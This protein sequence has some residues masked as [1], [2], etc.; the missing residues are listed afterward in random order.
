MGLTGGH[1]PTVFPVRSI[2]S[3]QVRSDQTLEGSTSVGSRQKL[4]KLGL[5]L[6]TAQAAE[7]RLESLE[8]SLLVRLALG[9]RLLPAQLLEKAQ[10]VNLHSILGLLRTLGGVQSLDCLHQGLVWNLS[11]VDP[12]VALHL[13]DLLQLLIQLRHL[14]LGCQI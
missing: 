3:V 11:T 8:G 7:N 13:L 14:V 4:L 12:N 10:L 2:H 9:L 1:V 6:A 5:S